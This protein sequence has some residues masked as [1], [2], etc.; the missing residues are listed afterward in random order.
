MG[1]QLDGCTALMLAAEHG[2]L[3]CLQLLL[4]AKAD[5]ALVDNRDHDCALTLACKSEEY[6]CIRA[7]LAGGADPEA[8]DAKGLSALMACAANGATRSMTLV[9][10]AGADLCRVND[11]GASALWCA[12]LPSR[13]LMSVR[14]YLLGDWLH[15][16]RP[17]VRFV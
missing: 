7:L 11:D 3:E 15:F 13:V 17:Q 9:L 12:C 5:P 14:V 1:E 8:T 16:V 10:D 2:H 6:E 4:N